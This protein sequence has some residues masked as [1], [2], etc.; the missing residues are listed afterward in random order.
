MAST[1]PNCLFYFCSPSSISN[2]T[3][4]S[5]TQLPL[6][7]S[8]SIFNGCN[9]ISLTKAWP[10]SS[11]RICAKFEQF[12]GEPPQD[13]LEDT[14]PP[15]LEAFEEDGEQEEEDD[16]WLNFFHN[17]GCMQFFFHNLVCIWSTIGLIVEGKWWFPFYVNEYFKCVLWAAVNFE[18]RLKEAAISMLFILYCLERHW[19]N[20]FNGSAAC[21]LTWRVQSGNRVKQV[22]HLCLQ[23]DWEP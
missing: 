19:C 8:H 20:L 23:E 12:Q 7:Y 22:Q 15:T 5:T 16:R 10:S 6:S 11:S 21:L 14:P 2:S 17:L 9:G 3:S 13:N 18:L 4:T 1:S